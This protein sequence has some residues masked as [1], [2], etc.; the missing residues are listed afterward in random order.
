MRQ[1]AL[2]ALGP[3]H[4]YD[5]YV[6]AVEIAIARYVVLHGVPQRAVLLEL[7]REGAA[8]GELDRLEFEYRHMRAA[9]RCIEDDL[10]IIEQRR[11][12]DGEGKAGAQGVEQ[13]R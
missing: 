9:A 2:A 8:A 11:R 3:P 12:L 13:G 10:R 7:D 6:P 4:P 5:N 1:D